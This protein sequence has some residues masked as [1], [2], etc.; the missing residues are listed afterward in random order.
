VSNLWYSADVGQS[1]L[2][3]VNI[4]QRGGNYGWAYREGTAPGPKS[5]SAPANFTSIDPIFEYGHT[6]G[7]NAIV[8]GIVYHGNRSPELQGVYFC[9]DYGSGEI[10]ALRYNGVSVTSQQRLFADPGISCFGIDPRNGDVLY[11]NLQSGNNSQIRRVVP[12]NAVPY[13]SSVTISSGNLVA[14]GHAGTLGGNYY[15]L[16]SSNLSLPAGSWSPVATNA[17][18]IIGDFDFTNPVAGPQLFYRLQLP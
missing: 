8:G 12:T 3:E 16:T 7:R 18:D 5:G 14:G 11:A 2:E 4:L 10:F 6:N 9:G 15:V 17:F 1:L 13:F